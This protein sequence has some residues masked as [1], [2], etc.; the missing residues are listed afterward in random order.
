MNDLYMH[1]NTGTIQTKEQ[2]MDDTCD[3]ELEISGLDTQ[4]DYFDD[5]IDQGEM[6]EVDENGKEI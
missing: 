5:L 1:I 2:W 4:E 6:V 3:E